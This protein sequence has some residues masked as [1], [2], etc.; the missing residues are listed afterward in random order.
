M[1]KTRNNHYVPRWYQ[2]GFFEPGRATYAYLDKTPDRTALADGRVVS[3]RERFESPTARCFWQKDLYST[4]FGTSVNDEVERRLFGDIDGRGSPAVRAFIGTDVGGWHRH[5]QTFFEYIDAQKLRTP[6]GLDWLRAQYPLLDQN[7]LMQEMQGIRMIHCTI[8]TEGVR[9][10][11]SAEDAG[12]KFI[13]SDHPVT[14][15]NHAVAPDPMGHDPGIAAKASQTI[16]PL[17]RDFCLILTNLEYARDPETNPLQKRTFARHYRMS[18][19]R[20]DAFIRTRKL[21]DLDVAQIN[22]ILKAQARRYIAAGKPEW[23]YPERMVSGAWRDLRTVLL[24]KDSLWQFGGELYAKYDSGHVHYQDEFGRTEKERDFLIKLKSEAPVRPRDACGC[25]SG[26]AYMDCCESKPESLRP[27]WTEHSIR[28]R[29]AML[30]NGF[31]NVLDF[32]TDPDWATVRRDMTDEK[33]KKLYSVYQALW[34]IETDL[35]TLLPKPDGGLRAVYTGSLH[36]SLIAEY[37]LGASLYFGDLLV[38]HPFLHAGTVK[39]NFSPVE[40]PSH[41]R[42][43]FLK[44]AL[45]FL[46]AL[47]LVRE[48]IVNLYPD[49]CN[50]D[51]HLRHQMMAMARMRAKRLRF[52]PRNDA[53]LFALMKEECERGIMAMPPDIVRAQLK[54]AMPQLDDAGLNRALADIEAMKE[55]DP[56]AVLQQDSG[57]ADESNGQCLLSKLAPNFEMT[58][59]LAQATGACIVTDNAHRWT[60]INRAVYGRRRAVKVALPRLAERMGRASFAFPQNPADVSLLW[61]D[62]S[63]VA[64][65]SAMRDVYK[66]LSNL[67]ERDRKPNVEEGLAARFRRT[68]AQTKAVIAKTG[69]PYKAGRVSCLFPIGGIQDNT[70]NR[71]LLMSSSEHHAPSVPMAFFIDDPATTAAATV[72]GR[73]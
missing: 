62:P 6:K 52:D 10:I 27:T 50:F 5:F 59:Y 65:R 23:L 8:W 58:L 36:P 3:G 12:I 57:E 15:Y 16:F 48:G 35:L 49:P 26:R 19:V 22:Y 29:N 1:S 18:M 55:L 13:V 73:T 42:Q 39:K 66:Y 14:V 9:E 54:K 20:S 67:G 32:H 2:A 45:F 44:Q 60:E 33:I 31:V 40:N 37:A 38:E 11:V 63:F 43:E 53:R 56:L 41:Y 72:R 68:H 69:T 70:V 4:F 46:T 21:T 30:Y 17:N 34:P 47:P 71:L 61:D 51:R 25:G 28:E 64:F 7:E 24:P